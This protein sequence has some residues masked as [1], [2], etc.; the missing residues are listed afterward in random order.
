[1]A[2]IRI[3]VNRA[4]AAGDIRLLGT[5]DH[6]TLSPS[7]YEREDW[8]SLLPALTIALNRGASIVWEES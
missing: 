4:P 8:M 6:V 3:S 5:G 1:M 7:V 2:K